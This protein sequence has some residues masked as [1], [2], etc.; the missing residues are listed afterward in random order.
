MG[1][2][3]FDDHEKSDGLRWFVADRRRKDRQEFEAAVLS[4]KVDRWFSESASCPCGARR[5]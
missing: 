5:P 4:G 2:V 1:N 3:E